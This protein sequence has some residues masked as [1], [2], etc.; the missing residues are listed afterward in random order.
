MEKQT[1]FLKTQI[2]FRA[3]VPPFVGYSDCFLGT[4]ISLRLE[5]ASSEN[6]NLKVRSYQSELCP[7]FEE[8]VEVPFGGAVSVS[9]N[10]FSAKFLLENDTFKT[11]PFRADV[12]SGDEKIA[13]VESE[14]TALPFDAWEGLSG[15]VEKVACLVRPRAFQTAR[16]VREVK[17][18]LEKEG[19]SNFSGTGADKS[20][21][22]IAFAT[23]FSIVK[24]EGFT[25][26]GSFDLTRP[27]SAAPPSVTSARK[28]DAF[29]LALF[30]SACLERMGLHAVLALAK[31][32]VGVGVWLY[33]SCFL[34]SVINDGAIVERYTSERA[35]QLLFFDAEDLFTDSGRDFAASC[36]RFL[37]KLKAGT[38]ECFV[39]LCRCRKE[40]FAPVPS[41]GA[42]GSGYEIYGAEKETAP[43]I[44]Q[45]SNAENSPKNKLWERGLADFSSRNPLLDFK[46]KNALKLL[47]PVAELVKNLTQDGGLKIRGGA[48]ETIDKSLVEKNVILT[49]LSER[50]AHATAMK[51]RRRNKE[52]IEETG[53]RILFVACGFLR[54]GEGGEAR[55]AP[56]VLVPAELAIARGKEGYCLS[57]SGEPFVNATLLEYLKQEFHIDVKGLDDSSLSVKEILKIFKRETAFMQGWEVTEEAYL[58]TFFFQRF[59]MWNDLR[60]HFHEFEK[61]GNVK[62]LMHGKTI[63]TPPMSAIEAH[64]EADGAPM[65]EVM[66]IAADAVP[67]PAAE[68]VL[69]PLPSDASQREAVHLSGSGKSF[70]L[71]GPPGTGKSQ[72]ITNMIAHALERG[73]SVLFV[74]EKKAALDVVKRRLNEIGIGDFCLEFKADQSEAFK[75]FRRTLLLKESAEEKGEGA[76]YVT[77]RRALQSAQDA[78]HQKRKLALS[79]HEAILAYLERRDYP[80]VLKPGSEFYESL[81]PEKLS[82]C[83]RLILSAASAAQECGGVFN[84]PFENVNLK[85]YSL[86]V[87]DRA[88]L[89]GKALLGEAAHFK[90]FLALVLDFFAQ[91]IGSFTQAR[92]EQLAGILKGLLSGKYDCY[93]KGVTIEE[94][95]LF[96]GANLR[97][98]ANL[99]FYEKHF[100]LLVNIEAELKELEAFLREGG[101]YRLNRAASSVKKRLERA[102]LH[103]LAEE[104]IPKY[105]EALVNIFSSRKELAANPLAESITD[106]SGHILSKRRAEFLAPLKELA[107]LASSVFA[108]FSPDR[109][110][111]GCIRAGSGCADPL[112][113]GYLAAKQSFFVAKER[114]LA[115]TAAERGR[116]E[117]EDILNYFSAKAAALLENADLLRG[118]CDY[119]AAEERL[120]EQGMKFIG[121][122]LEEGAL[123]PD[124]VLGGF[125]K[126]LFE[127]FLSANIPADPQLSRMTS[128]NGE[129]EAELFAL[130]SEREQARKR[131]QLKN[132]LIARLPKNGECKEEL[133]FL[134]R[135]EKGSKRGRLRNLFLNAPALMKK[136][137]PCLLMSPD[138]VAQYLI[139]KADEYD[140]VIFDEASQMTTPE[141]V[142]ALARAKQAVIVGDNC[143]LPPTPFFRTSFSDEEEEGD[144]ESVLDT[145]LASGFE[146]RSLLWHYRSR[147]ESLVAF[148]NAMYYENRLGTFPSPH[149]TESRVSLCRVEG[150][151][152]RGGSKRNKKEAEA[153]VGEIIRRLSDPELKK[154]S[155][156]VVTFSGVQREE[157]ERILSREIA[158]HSLEEVAYGGKEPLFVK[159]LENVQGDERDVILFSV[160]YGFDKE[161]KLFYNFGALNRAGGWRRLNVAC[162]RA[163]EEMIVFSSISASDIDL[164]RTSS[165]GMVGLKAFLEFAEKGRITLA[166]PPDKRRRESVGKYLAEEL[167]ACGYECRT[168][169][170]TGNFKIDVAVLDPLDKSRY[171]LGILTS[172]GEGSASDRAVLLPRM[173]KKGGWNLLTVSE[174]A[175]FNNPKREI[176]RIKDYLDALTGTSRVEVLRYGRPYRYVKDEGGKTEA[177]VTDGHGDKEITER[178]RAIVQKE[179]PISRAFLKKRCMESFGIR[180]WGARA[181]QRLDTLISRLA[182][183]LERVGGTEYFYQNLRALLPNKFRREGKNKRRKV[184]EDFTPFETAALIKGILEEKVTLYDD[185]LVSSVSSVYGVKGTAAFASFIASVIAYGEEKGMFQRSVSGRISLVNDC[186]AK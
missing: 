124:N 8:E 5:N 125:E 96:R 7:L 119:K 170:G 72:T 144:L 175:Y 48:E 16:I 146:E 74:A 113:E 92:A 167:S 158:R 127:H 81:T 123:S 120:K 59:L 169:V 26:E 47:A 56:I 117:G 87:R 19:V 58:S 51:L 154:Q 107:S 17:R 129:R 138:A 104:D 32:K 126:S 41:R 132:T 42:A 110:F 106:R 185:E 76:E 44:K 184:A 162:S 23:L 36:R 109:F 54:Y 101:D 37:Q 122:A 3:T 94:F 70:V 20:E 148:S 61:N 152:E 166:L 186:K 34:E 15:I 21:V 134:F 98:D 78:L 140:L 45:K 139:P 30:T 183:P 130:L 141:A 86:A 31:D 68:D 159:N 60:E 49:P 177:F 178:L 53:A 179:E 35:G 25:R 108:Q 65:T 18:R 14:I 28:I 174:V 91:K 156:G 181:E 62:A 80:D 90:C 136:I 38:F 157:I 121:E 95:M 142:P 4:K 22:K 165:K 93:F 71:H 112:F 105:I 145:A 133:A 99:A 6:V 43:P 168:G 29:R 164:N 116:A 137:C 100:K 64:I 73:K 27:V 75:Q 52:A 115:S 180:S 160:C 171:L 10:G 69:L 172:G 24:E 39:D 1:D 11:V 46:G 151:Y 85:E 153:L 12:F 2:T 84:T 128:G 131:V 57:S 149:A 173:L 97:L 13:S 176:K 114:Y 67:M 88:L 33:D 147:H 66:P 182:L 63:E 143:Q 40:G 82:E 55:L 83:K 155:I 9:F 163:R 77:S 118:R 150:V 89:A 161:G 103:P 135:L 50:E 79:V 102:A 111:E